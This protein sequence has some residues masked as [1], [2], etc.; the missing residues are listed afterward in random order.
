MTDIIIIGAG[1][2]PAY[3]VDGSY[4]ISA[5][6]GYKKLKKLGITPD[7]LIGDFDS[8]GKIPNLGCEIITFP[9]QKDDTDTMLAVKEAHKR[10]FNRIYLSGCS[11]GLLDHT[12]A[13][14]QTLLYAKRQGISAFLVGEGETALVLENEKI[15][16][17]PDREIRFS[18]FA[19]DGI[20][21]GVSICGAKYSA[22]DIALTCDFPLGVSNCFSCGIASISVKNGALLMIYEGLPELLTYDPDGGDIL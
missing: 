19:I 22:E 18:L 16:V 4:C 5:D 17:Y 6:A 11:G 8:S 9:I 15:T 10:G 12:V 2:S 7:L 20:A 14:L 21:K 13:N 3:Y 1:P